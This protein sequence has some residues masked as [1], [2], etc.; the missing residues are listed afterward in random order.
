MFSN[1][2]RKA[3]IESLKCLLFYANTVQKTEAFYS[4]RGAFVELMNQRLALAQGKIDMGSLTAAGKMIRSKS[5]R[6]P[7]INGVGNSF[8]CHVVKEIAIWSTALFG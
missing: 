3:Q 5:T 7:M 4:V 8:E 2:A 6:M 1:Q